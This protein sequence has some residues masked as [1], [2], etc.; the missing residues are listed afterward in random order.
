ME[1]ISSRKNQFIQHLRQLT[2]SASERNKNREFVLDSEKLLKEALQNSV[3]VKSVFWRQKPQFEL[4]PEIDE[5][6]LPEE[7]FQYVSPLKESKGPIFIAEM[8]EK[9]E[10]SGD[11][12]IILENLQDPGNVGTIVRTAN[13]MSFDAVILVGECADIYNP[14][15]VR[16]TMGAIFRQHVVSTNLDGLK[17]ILSE[18]NLS[19]CGAALSDRA[20]NIQSVNLEKCAVAIGSE[21]K[22]LSAKMLEM[23]DLEVI[24]PMAEG[25]ESLNAAIAASIVMWE[26]K[27]SDFS[28]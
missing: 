10:I 26:R 1:Y 2:S 17:E 9:R 7:L 6:A 4:P 18:K 19:L 14:K 25:S 23:C 24:I 12:I 5:Y 11:K 8:P 13:A 20:M 16:A 3:K 15:T 21:G 22:G 28:C 27:R